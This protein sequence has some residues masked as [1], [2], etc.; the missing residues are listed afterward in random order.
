[1][2]RSKG[3]LS[4][5]QAKEI[6]QEISE[7]LGTPYKYNFDMMRLMELLLCQ[8]IVEG[9]TEFPEDADITDKMVTVEIPLIGDLTI[10]PEVFHE[11]HGMTNKPSIH[12]G[13]EFNP[14]S[15]FM[16]DI[17]RAYMTHETEMPDLLKAVYTER[18]Q[19][20]YRKLREEL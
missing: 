12:F 1:M 18:V 16:Q 3:S 4:T 8:R 6:S 13:F 11:S 5:K 9:V 15:A 19:E 7:V 14:T 10:V 20:L 17:K 2:P